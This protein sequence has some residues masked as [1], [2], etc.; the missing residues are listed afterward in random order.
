MIT[1]I[2]IE[3][4]SGKIKSGAMQFK[5][6]WP[7]LFLRGDDCIQYISEYNYLFSEKPIPNNFL[8]K[9][10]YDTMLNEVLTKEKK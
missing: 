8:I 1:K 7:G 9:K 6:D 5:N 4:G 3:G 2:P 10:M